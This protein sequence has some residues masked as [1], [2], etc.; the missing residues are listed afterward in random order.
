[1]ADW[2]FDGEN[3]IIK[4]PVGAGNTTFNVDQDL[5]SAWKRWVLSGEGQYD[6]AF[7]VEGGTP[8]GSTGL[9]TG[10]TYLLTN[11]WKLMAADHDHQAFIVG[12][13]FSD[14]GIVS[15]PNPI[16]Q[17]T[18]FASGSVNAQGVAT[19]GVQQVILD[20][21]KLLIEETHQLLGFNKNIPMTA[22]KDTI[23]S[24]DIVINISGDC[25][26]VTT[27]DRQ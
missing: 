3:K 20:D 4:E 16:G 13:L 25:E 5:Y 21:I 6:A 26:N 22:T 17:S 11:G 24:G 15:T 12:N 27:L 18:I 1:M 8:I 2:I 14:D 10:T 19:G 9:F 23:T 7:I